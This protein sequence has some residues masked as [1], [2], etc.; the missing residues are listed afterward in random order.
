MI[1]VVLSALVATLVPGAGFASAPC[2]SVTLEWGTNGSAAGQLNQPLDLAIDRDAN[3]YVTDWG[4]H[5]VQK[6]NSTGG[7][8]TMW[9]SEGTLDGQF[10][11]PWGIATDLANNVYVA[12]GYLSRIQVFT[13]DGSFLRSWAITPSIGV[14]VD[15]N[16]YVYTVD[17]D[18][19]NK[20]APTG[21]LTAQW[22]SRGTGPGQFENPRGIG[23]DS[24]GNVYVGDAGNGRVVKYNNSGTFLASWGPVGL[25]SQLK[26]GAND[27]VFVVGNGLNPDVEVYDT[28]GNQICK[29]AHAFPVVA[30]SGSMG[31]MCVLEWTDLNAPQFRIQES[32][33]FQGMLPPPFVLEWGATLPYGVAIDSH[34][35]V[36][37]AQRGSS[38]HKIHRYASLGAPIS[39][40]GDL[41]SDLA[42]LSNAV[43]NLAFD[44]SDHLFVADLDNGRIKKFSADGA[45]L[46]SWSVTSP[47]EGLAVDQAGFVYTTDYSDQ[48]K[49]YTNDGALVTSWGSTGSAFGQFL[50]PAGIAVDGGFI[51]V[52]DVVNNRVQKFTADGAFVLAWG[53]SGTG[54]GQF[55]DSPLYIGVDDQH[56]VY[57]TDNSNKI[58]I[59]TSS[60]AFLSAWGGSGSGPGQFNYPGQLTFDRAGNVYSSD[61]FNNR[62]QMFGP[63]SPGHVI[64][65]LAG[66]DGSIFPGR[67]VNVAD[68][69]TQTFQITSNPGNY[70]TDVKLDGVSAG[71]KDTYTFA[72]VIADHTIS[73]TFAD[74]VHVSIQGAVA[75]DLW[76]RPYFPPQLQPIRS[77]LVEMWHDGAAMPAPTYSDLDGSFHVDCSDCLP[78]DSVRVNTRNPWLE[79]DDAQPGA[80]HQPF[81]AAAVSSGPVLQLIWPPAGGYAGDAAN[82]YFIAEQD[83]RLFWSEHMGRVLTKYVMYVRNA[84]AKPDAGAF[85]GVSLDINDRHPIS[86]FDTGMA[87]YKDAVCHELVHG[88]IIQAFGHLLSKENAADTADHSDIEAKGLDEGLADYFTY[89]FTEQP[90]FGADVPSAHRPLNKTPPT[91]L[92]WCDGKYAD[93]MSGYRAAPAVS[94]ALYDLRK[95]LNVGAPSAPTKAEFDQWVFG[96]TYAL[97]DLPLDQRTSLRLMQTLAASPLVGM[98]RPEVAPAFE[99]HNIKAQPDNSLLACVIVNLVDAQREITATEQRVSLLWSRVEGSNFYRIYRKYTTGGTGLGFGDVVGDSLTDTTFVYSDPDITAQLSFAIVP[100][101]STGDEG[102][103]SVQV[104]TGLLGVENQRQAGKLFLNARPNPSSAN[105]TIEFSLPRESGASL[106]VFDILGRRVKQWTWSKLGAGPHQVS[107]DGRAQ[108]GRSIPPGVLFY[109]LDVGI[110]HLRQ[111]LIH[112]R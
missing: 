7:F 87:Q 32:D 21:T 99:A 52:V 71:L 20:F 102:N 37:V 39:E 38:V 24:Q 76:I 105:A 110:Q 67:A 82:C 30:T 100:V 84:A 26:V 17:T 43:G 108:D 25:N 85:T 86:S 28:M 60:G 12:D 89:A 27:L 36:Y 104:D 44:S 51:Y 73:A 48:V 23:V 66:P 81:A 75:G 42:Q 31:E 29:T 56:R 98:L 1:F 33:P 54:T 91:K 9:G 58:Q 97:G 63:A 41:G 46:G 69:G 15:Q 47:T 55:A 95:S 22:G 2:P 80:I 72:N 45:H 50:A 57:V 11:Q 35:D 88:M 79:V 65:P 106:A 101:D 4:N 13:S 6:F 34:G 103:P 62:I 3:V 92:P 94:G 93:H 8:V 16:G 53:K 10:D 14:A 68:G 74:H 111:K 109:R 19:V 77:A 5:R 49:K 78:S 90:D 64:T 96:A 61:Y 107:W 59:F 83:G 18:H 40:W 70:I 112:L